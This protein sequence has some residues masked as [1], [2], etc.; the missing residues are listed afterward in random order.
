MSKNLP[1]ENGKRKAIRIGAAVMCVV[2]AIGVVAMA[3][4]LII[5]AIL[6]TVG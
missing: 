5:S 1:E 2:M 4:T 3:A 6:K